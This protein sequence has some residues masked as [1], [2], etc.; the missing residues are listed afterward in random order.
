[1]VGARTGSRAADIADVVV[2]GNGVMG[3]SVALEVARQSPKSRVSVVGPP[4]RPMSATSAAGAMLN[5]FGEVTRYTARHPATRARFALAREAL[6]AWPGWIETLAELA[7]PP[8]GPA[9]RASHLPGTFVLLS[10]RSGAVAAD[11]F[12]AMR[13]AAEEYGEPY[14]LVDARDVDGLAPRS[15]A[16]PLRVLHLRREGSVDARSLLA[17]LEAATARLGV[18]HVAGSV[19]SLLTG[20]AGGARDARGVGAAGGAGGAEGA[21][22]AGVAGDAGGVGDAGGAGDSAVARGG[23][24]AGGAYGGA[25]VVGEA[26]GA[27]RGVRLDDGSTLAA[28]IVVLAAGAASSS[29]AESVLPPG[30]VPPMLSGTGVSLLVTRTAA[31]GSGARHVLRTPNRAATCGLHVV[32]MTEPGDQYIGATNLI[33]TR[34]VTGAELGSTHA[35]MR[36]VCEQVDHD[37]AFARVQRWMAGA[38]PIPLDCFPLLGRCSVPGL[39]FATGTYR[40]GFHCSP[41]LAP[42]LASMILGS[43]DGDPHL[44]AFV[45]ERLPIALMSPHDAVTDTVTHAL[46]TM[47]EQ[48]VQLP[49]WVDSTPL[50]EWVRRRT[51]RLYEEL[52]AAVALA[53]EIVYPQF[54][55]PKSTDDPDPVGRL[56]TYLRAAH[57]HHGA[58]ARAPARDAATRE[59]ADAAGQEG[60][61][62]SATDRLFS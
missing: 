52:D 39:I 44:A 5:C 34:P 43:S 15:D 9:L 2:V 7:G 32:P 31:S 38:R 8:A 42:R 20:D 13:A 53:P 41:A 54:L 10:G 29:L 28:G 47:G 48:G 21:E 50:D 27:V 18:Q 1:M 49:F 55:A 22:G 14:E 46:D 11:N 35:L 57:A 24:A 62:A 3:L 4:H 25:G 58:P 37:L 16:R 51:E 36:Q 40:D 45:P 30:A 33:T 60:V 12:D 26:G 6:D 56:R 61:H 23:A 59:V 17:A 19:R